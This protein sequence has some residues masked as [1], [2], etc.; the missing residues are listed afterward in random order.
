MSNQKARAD[1]VQ[2]PPHARRPAGALQCLGRREREGRSRRAAPR[3]S[4]PAAGRWRRP[5]ATRTARACRSTLPSRTSSASS[6]R[7]ISRSRSISR[8]VTVA[9][10]AAVGESVTRAIKAGAIGCNLEDQ[11]IRRRLRSIRS[12]TRP[13]ASARLAQPRIGFRSRPSSM[14]APTCFSRP[15]RRSTTRCCSMQRSS[16][17]RPTRTPAPAGSSCRGSWMRT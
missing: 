6:R 16:A 15:M 13:R 8:R 10:P 14:R 11:V 3:R 9:R 4:P 17:P 1:D 5:M 7:W 2:E 12:T